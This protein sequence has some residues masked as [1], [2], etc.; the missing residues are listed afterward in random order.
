M[1]S[2]QGYSRG[3]AVR[4]LRRS[5]QPRPTLLHIVRP[6]LHAPYRLALAMRHDAIQTVANSQKEPNQPHKRKREAGACEKDRQDNRQR[7]CN[8]AR[9]EAIVRPNRLR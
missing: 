5:H 2:E 9:A 6:P 1:E 7:R 8:G 3:E 4:R